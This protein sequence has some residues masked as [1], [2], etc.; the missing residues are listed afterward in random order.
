MHKYKLRAKRM[1][2]PFCAFLPKEVEAEQWNKDGDVSWANVV[3]LGKELDQKCPECKNC[4]S[5]HGKMPYKVGTYSYIPIC[6]GDY[7]IKTDSNQNYLLNEKKFEYL[8]T[9]RD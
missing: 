3:P 8:Y 4:F 2:N 6:P 5:I 1:I 7:I 9:K